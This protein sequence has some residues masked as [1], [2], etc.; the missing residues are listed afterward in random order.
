VRE[1]EGY[2]AVVTGGVLGV[3]GRIMHMPLWTNL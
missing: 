1:V 3:E 2:K